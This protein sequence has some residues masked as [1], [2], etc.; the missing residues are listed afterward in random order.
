MQKQDDIFLYRY[1]V[2]WADLDPQNI[3]FNPNYYAFFD[4]ALNDYMLAIGYSLREGLAGDGADMLAVHSEADFHAS[5]RLDD[6]LEI[7]VRLGRVG[8]SSF[9]LVF[10]L[11]RGPELLV[12]GRITYVAVGLES[13]RPIP[14]PPRFL[15]AIRN[16]AG[17][18]AGSLM[19]A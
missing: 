3:V 12:A 19:E 8:R 10:P 7:G 4:S 15:V 18:A 9:Q 5:A 14:V 11:W 2:R 17:A 6:T 1:R 13:R 16:H